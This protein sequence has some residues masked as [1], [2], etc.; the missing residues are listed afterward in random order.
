MKSPSKEGLFGLAIFHQQILHVSLTLNTS[1][2]NLIEGVFC[3]YLVDKYGSWVPRLM[4]PDG[5]YRF[6][7]FS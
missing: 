6:P 1:L 5:A 7:W 4:L 2:N 3:L